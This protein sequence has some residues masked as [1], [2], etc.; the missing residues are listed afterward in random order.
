M[1]PTPADTYFFRALSAAPPAVQH[2]M[3]QLETDAVRAAPRFRDREKR[4][5]YLQMLCSDRILQSELTRI[6]RAVAVE[7]RS[8]AELAVELAVEQA[9]AEALRRSAAEL[10]GMR[11]TLAEAMARLDSLTLEEAAI[12]EGAV[13]RDGKE[14]VPRLDSK[15]VN[16]LSVGPIDDERPA[17]DTEEPFDFAYD[18]GFSG[19]W[20]DVE[21]VLKRAEEWLMIK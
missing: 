14:V 16:E 20:D 10:G 11:Q 6:K 12:E 3:L 7:R 4:M 21:R 18:S 15:A 8:A 2:R 13:Y 17:K 9:T 5:C 19:D 1:A